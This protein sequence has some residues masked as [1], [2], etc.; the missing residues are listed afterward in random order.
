M[1]ILFKFETRVKP[2]LTVLHQ[3][4]E[5]RGDGENPTG[6]RLA[7]NPGSEGAGG[8]REAQKRYCVEVMWA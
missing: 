4:G 5:G 7:S 1:L 2:L 6:S 3:R 8:R